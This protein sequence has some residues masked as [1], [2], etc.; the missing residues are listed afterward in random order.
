HQPEI[1]SGRVPGKEI[2]LEI[3]RAVES[4]RS[5][6]RHSFEGEEARGPVRAEIEHGPVLL[7]QRPVATPRKPDWREALASGDPA[8]ARRRACSELDRAKRL[9]ALPS[10]A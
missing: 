6:V 10:E 4:A 9:P 5:P 1:E 7:D 3:Q 8:C 2:P